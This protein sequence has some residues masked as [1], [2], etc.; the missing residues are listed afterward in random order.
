[1]LC[2]LLFG[3]NESVPDNILFF[4]LFFKSSVD[5]VTVGQRV[6]EITINKRILTLPDRTWPTRG[7]GFGITVK[8]VVDYRGH[9]G[10]YCWVGVGHFVCRRILPS[11]LL[12]SSHLNCFLRKCTVSPHFFG[13]FLVLITE[14]AWAKWLFVSFCVPVNCFLA[15]VCSSI[16]TYPWHKPSGQLESL[17]WLYPPWTP[18]LDGRPGNLQMQSHTISSGCK[19][20]IYTEITPVLHGTFKEPVLTAWI[21]KLVWAR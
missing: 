13:Q 7:K 12:S 20:L 6:V 3:I 18:L 14:F 9:T 15:S 2:D 5:N 8:D 16:G 19:Q 17:E 21:V 11:M 4:V 10:E 1:M